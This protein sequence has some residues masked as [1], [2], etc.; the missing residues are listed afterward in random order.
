MSTP[1]K[2]RLGKGLDALLSGFD[3]QAPDQVVQVDLDRIRPNP[4]QPRQD[5]DD[6]KLG[7]LAQS[8]TQ[9]GIVQPVILRAEGDLM[10]RYQLVA[11]ERRWRAARIA[12]LQQIPA[13]IRDFGDDEMTEIALIEN[14]QR[15]DLNPI[16]EAGAYRALME[17]FGLTQEETARKV[18]KSRPV[19]ANAVRLLNLVPEVQEMVARGLL[20]SG[21]ARALLAVTDP[22]AQIQLARRVVERQLTVQE[23]EA[24]IKKLGG[25]GRKSA[26]RIA[27]APD[28]ELFSLEECLRTALGTKVTI[29][30]RARK[31]SI[32]IEYYGLDDLDRL[33]GL[34]STAKSDL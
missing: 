9:H 7:E 29:K 1:K 22:E 11:G 3:D 33:V 19:V 30:P 21:H 24:L 32:V 15:E 26:K 28:P 10:G 17:T 2:K 8:I 27:V 5:F 34:I 18:G 16:E 31:G 4:F 14:L 23:L 12:G 6:E 20:A 25:G 13:V